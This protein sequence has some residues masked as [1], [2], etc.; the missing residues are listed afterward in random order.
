MRVVGRLKQARWQDKDGKTQSKV[1]VIAEHIEYKP[2]FN[3][4]IITTEEESAATEESADLT[5][6]PVAEETVF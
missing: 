4:S 6:A 1:Y 5:E 2:K 3:N